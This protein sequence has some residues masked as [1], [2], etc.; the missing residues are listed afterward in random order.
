MAG[1][2][3]GGA[4]EKVSLSSA[5]PRQHHEVDNPSQDHGLRNLLPPLSPLFFKTPYT[6]AY[7]HLFL[8]ASISPP[9][10]Y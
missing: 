6:H 10:T 5:L 4:P 2:D 1:H 3:Q 9:H 7:A 8:L